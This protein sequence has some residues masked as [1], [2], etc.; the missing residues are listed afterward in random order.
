MDHH[1]SSYITKL[2]FEKEKPL[3]GR[4]HTSTNDWKFNEIVA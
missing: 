3:I 4:C 1:H 2:G